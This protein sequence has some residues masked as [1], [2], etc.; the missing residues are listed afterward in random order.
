MIFKSQ[1]SNKSILLPF[2]LLLTLSCSVENNSSVMTSWNLSDGKE[3]P[4][5]R[6]LSRA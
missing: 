6:P 3:F 5:S 4:E 1:V 2:L